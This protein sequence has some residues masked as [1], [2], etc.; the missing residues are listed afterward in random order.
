MTARANGYTN[1]VCV[2][3]DIL[4]IGRGFVFRL[5]KLKADLGEVVKFGDGT[6]FD[7]SL[8]ATFENAV[9]ERVNVRFFSEVDK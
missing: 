9:E 5:V 3:G 8:D 2:F 7:L 4:Y 6:S 1:A